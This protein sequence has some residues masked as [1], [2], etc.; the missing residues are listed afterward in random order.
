MAKR[1]TARKKRRSLPNVKAFLPCEKVIYD[2]ITTCATLVSL[3]SELS[4]G[5]F[6]GRI[7][8]FWLFLQLTDGMIGKYEIEIEVQDLDNASVLLRFTGGVAEFS[9]RP[10]RYDIIMMVPPLLLR[11]PTGRLAVVA[12]ADD[13]VLAE[14]TF[15][16]RNVRSG[17]GHADDPK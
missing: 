14:N 4:I 16:I 6:P 15:T 10:E 13:E 12:F 11:R 2:Q 9:Y 1:T 8:P 5:A 3:F 17:N 7:P